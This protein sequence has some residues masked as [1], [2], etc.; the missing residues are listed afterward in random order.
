VG[1]CLIGV[2]AFAIEGGWVDH[3]DSAVGLLWLKSNGNGHH[4]F[5]TGTL[6]APQV[7]LTAAHCVSGHTAQGFFTGT[8]HKHDVA[9]LAEP[10]DMLKHETDK[11]ASMPGYAGGTCPNRSGDF[12]LVHLKKPLTRTRP[13]GWAKAAA[14][15]KGKTCSAIG[16]GMHVTWGGKT[17]LE[18][19][20]RAT[21]KIELMDRDVIKVDWKTGVADHGDS[22]G[23]LYC[24]G[25]AIAGVVSCHNDGSAPVHK[26]EYY[27]RIDRAKAWVASTMGKWEKD[28]KKAIEQARAQQRPPRAPAKQTS[29][30]RQAKH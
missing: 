7:V 24:G 19:K 13:I 20:R 8:G 1:F 30:T 27:G 2:P 10:K 18:Q 5:C 16:Y 23:P 17:T 26:R 29:Q 12:G 25:D 21:D 14:Y 4:G 11:V 9:H 6:I 3:R 28:D 22:G 15:A